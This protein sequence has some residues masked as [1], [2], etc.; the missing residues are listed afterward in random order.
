MSNMLQLETP[1]LDWVT[2]TTWDEKRLVERLPHVLELCKLYNGE[3]KPGRRRGYIG[4][5]HET[6]NGN[7]FVG[8]GRQEGTAH[9]MVIASGQ[10][11]HDILPIFAVGILAGWARC[12]RLDIQVTIDRPKGWDQWALANRLNDIGLTIEYKTSTA[13]TPSGGRAKLSTVYINSRRSD[14]YYRVYEKM[15]AGGNICLRLEAELKGRVAEA[16]AKKQAAY[17]ARTLFPS[18]VAE[19]GHIAARDTGL[20]VAY[21]D[22]L[23]SGGSRTVI[24]RKADRRRAWLEGVC[25]PALDR[26]YHAHEITDRQ[27]IDDWIDLITRNRGY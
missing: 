12:K 7:V 9:F 6:D 3:D 25:L 2:L 23:R 21:G 22:I 27:F 4:E 20:M 10:I 18:V 26:Y 16:V 19:L 1:M 17:G 13:T 24:R 14:R 5:T 15:T 11:A 8:K